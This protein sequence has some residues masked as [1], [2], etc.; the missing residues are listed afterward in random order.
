M[1]CYDFFL[2][3]ESLPKPQKSPDFGTKLLLGGRTTII[4]VIGNV[5]FFL[6]LQ[7]NL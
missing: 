5:G 7:Y 2:A 4:I 6:S 3:P 1:H